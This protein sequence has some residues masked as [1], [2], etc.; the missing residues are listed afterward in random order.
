M[1]ACA[2]LICRDPVNEHVPTKLDTKGGVEIT[3]YEGHTVAD[4]GLLKMDFLGLRTLTVISKAKANIK[5]NF[6]IDIKEEEIPFDDP[7][8]FKLMGSGH[9][10]GVFQV[11]SA[12]MTATIK[13]MKPT[14][15]KHVVALI[16]LYRPGP[17]GAGM[18]SSYINRMNGKEPAVSYDDRLDDILARPT[19]PWSTRS[20]LCSSPSRCAASPRANRTRV[21]VSPW[22]RK[23]SSCSRRRCSTG[24]MARTRPPT[25]TG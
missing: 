6:G 16:A 4:M 15:Y 12:G 8:I 18:V 9:T 11:E 21:S 7:E 13:N 1:H 23:R 14:E 19:A 25:T 10:A 24:R 20:R 2:V 5:K 17:L 22:L 3:Q